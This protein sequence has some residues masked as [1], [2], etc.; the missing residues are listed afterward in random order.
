[1]SLRAML[2]WP[3]YL[4]FGLI[5]GEGG[6]LDQPGSVLKDLNPGDINWPVACLAAASAAIAVGLLWQW[7][8]LRQ[9]RA[10]ISDQ[11]AWRTDLAL[12]AGWRLGVAALLLA[13]P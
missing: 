7:R 13:C 4:A 6:G 5:V 3:V 10:Q 1:M 12:A 8:A 9:I 2:L 11:T